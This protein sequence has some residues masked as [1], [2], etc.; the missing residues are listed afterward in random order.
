[1]TAFALTTF[2]LSAL[3]L[4][5]FAL[6]AFALAAFALASFALSAFAL[7]A[8]ALSAFAASAPAALGRVGHCRRGAAPSSRSARQAAAGC[9]GCGARG[10]GTGVGCLG[11]GEGL[12]HR[13]FF[14]GKLLRVFRID[15]PPRQRVRHRLRRRAGSLL[16]VDR[17]H[18]QAGDVGR[19]HVDAIEVPLLVVVR[20]ILHRIEQLDARREPVHLRL[21]VHLSE[22]QIAG[23]SRVASPNADKLPD[24]G[25]RTPQDGDRQDHLQQG[26]AA[27]CVDAHGV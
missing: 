24:R 11:V 15:D 19:P 17:H 18:L 12:L 3:P 6:A 23:L 21:G 2:A 7:S 14:L 20:R 13:R 26:E 16:D 25:Q 5:A 9:R 4:A 10:L 1:L 8:F 27:F 22:C